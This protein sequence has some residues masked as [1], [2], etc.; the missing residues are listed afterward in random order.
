MIENV[1]EFFHEFFHLQVKELTEFKAESIERDLTKNILK[2][3]FFN[4]RNLKNVLQVCFFFFWEKIYSLRRS[5]KKNQ[6][7]FV[8][9]TK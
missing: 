1:Y 7:K 3:F 9:Y 8:H 2:N 5:K 6:S 4:F